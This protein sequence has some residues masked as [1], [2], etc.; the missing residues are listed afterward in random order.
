[1]VV[2]SGSAQNLPRGPPL[3]QA[4]GAQ[5][6]SGLDLGIN[7]DDSGVVRDVTREARGKKF[8]SANSLR[9]TRVPVFG[10]RCSSQ[11]YV[12]LN[13]AVSISSN[14]FFLNFVQITHRYKEE[15]SD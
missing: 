3:N 13:Y 2:Y 1:V 11:L 5:K 4:F 14:S 15:I 6:K 8:P 9:G 10:P 7:Q 12:F